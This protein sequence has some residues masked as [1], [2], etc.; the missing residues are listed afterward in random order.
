M[1]FLFRDDTRIQRPTT[2]LGRIH[3]FAYAKIV[4]SDCV[5]R[6]LKEEPP[7]ITWEATQPF[8]KVA[9]GIT[10][11]NNFFQKIMRN[12]MRERRKTFAAE[13]MRM[14]PGVRHKLIYDHIMRVMKGDLGEV[15]SND[16]LTAWGVI[17][18]R[19]I[20]RACANVPETSCEEKAEFISHMFGGGLQARKSLLRT[21]CN[22]CFEIANCIAPLTA[23]D[24]KVT[25]GDLDKSGLDSD[26][27]EAD[28]E[29]ALYRYMAEIDVP[30]PNFVTE[31]L[32][33]PFARFDGHKL[34]ATFV[35]WAMEELCENVC[36]GAPPTNEVS[37]CEVVD[38]IFKCRSIEDKDLFTNWV[39]NA[40]REGMKCGLWENLT[41][42]DREVFAY[43]TNITQ[44]GE[45]EEVTSAYTPM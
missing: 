11:T 31:I 10:L 5:P 38:F 28:A 29:E 22:K 24:L 34:P 21:A 35:V 30:A 42:T 8:E 9:S 3:D 44:A 32:M 45:D 2:G 36:R 13:M 17:P 6:F 33:D 14:N 27:D 43:C 37:I 23:Q 4:S 39:R 12:A 20:L 16:R 26:Y 41:P 40:F 19:W 1:P 18:T 15:F 7:S 25:L